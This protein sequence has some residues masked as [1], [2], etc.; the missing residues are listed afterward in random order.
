MGSHQNDT[1]EMSMFGLHDIV[2]AESSPMTQSTRASDHWCTIRLTIKVKNELE[3]DSEQK[4]YLS[5]EENDQKHVYVED[6]PNPDGFRW[7]ITGVPEKVGPKH[8]GEIH[9]FR[10]VAWTLRKRYHNDP[11]RVHNIIIGCVK[12]G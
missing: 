10:N 9:I 4:F 5:W 12:K 7:E 3:P 2:P 8:N 6:E 11:N 1:N